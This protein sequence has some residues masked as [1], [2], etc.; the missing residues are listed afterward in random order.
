MAAADVQPPVP[1]PAAPEP[2]PAVPDYL[3]SPNAVFNDVGVQWRYGKAPDYSKTRKVWE[4]G[5]K[6][7]HAA[8]S[9]PQLV[10][11]LVK[12]WEVE[13]SFKPRLEDWRT[14]DHERYS[15]AINGGPPQSGEHMLKVGT[16]NAIIAPNEYYSPENSDFASSHKTFKRMM[17][18][19]AWEVVEVYSGPPQVAF[20]WR[21][22]GVMKN[23]YVG[24]NDKGEKVVAK[25]HGGPI[26]IFGV[27]VAK[28]DDKVRLQ[29]LDTW[30]DPLDM[31]RQIAP[32][33]IVNKE[34]MNRKVDPESA[35]DVDSHYVPS[36]PKVA[37]P[38]QP[39]GQA[40]ATEPAHPISATQSN[41]EAIIP[42][43]DGVKIAEE[44]NQAGKEPM[45]PEEILPT[46][47][48]NSTGQRADAFVPHQ[49]ADSSKPASESNP[50]DATTPATTVV[51][52]AAS[53][54]ADAKLEHPESNFHDA[55]EQQ[56]VEGAGSTGTVA[57][58]EKSPK[59]QQ[60][61]YTSA[62]TGNISDRMVPAPD[63]SVTTGVHDA[64]D[65]HLESSTAEVHPHPHATETATQVGRGE[66][67]AVP[68]ASEETR[69][70]HEEMSR[71]SGGECPFLMNRE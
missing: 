10:E 27:T 39:K 16:Y 54:G 14:I 17:P 59:Q 24:F 25:A 70:T 46:H 64:L 67:V 60:S 43:H 19:F 20:K 48:S 35:L 4:E 36:E 55:H 49:G 68:A 28:V 58:D 30:F 22:W 69:L 11:N 51:E 29:E 5:K 53:Q 34:N 50:S 8:G 38:E 6:M 37:Q 23:D 33:G 45:A 42:G 61:I 56:P 18:T 26:E 66:A 32:K 47:F 40:K 41:N 7:N 2:A 63:E 9:L 12:N 15:F 31:F 1:E 62:V 65:T 52:S 44:S 3:A 71:I 13:A 57:A 21:H